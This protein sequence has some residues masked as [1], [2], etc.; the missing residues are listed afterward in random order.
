M[1]WFGQRICMCFVNEDVQSDHPV[2]GDDGEKGLH[3]DWLTRPGAT[4]NE[5]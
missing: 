1:A 5:A 3:T 4:R 2:W